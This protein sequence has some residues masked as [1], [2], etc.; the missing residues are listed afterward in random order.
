ML[1]IHTVQKIRASFYNF[2]P[3]SFSVFML[4]LF[5]SDILSL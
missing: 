1:F 5:L 2:T 3:V 4:L